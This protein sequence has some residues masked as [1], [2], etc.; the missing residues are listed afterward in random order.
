MSWLGGLAQGSG[1]VGPPRNP[2]RGC[3]NDGGGAWGGSGG[4]GQGLGRFHADPLYFF[5]PFLLQLFFIRSECCC[6]HKPIA[7]EDSCRD[8]DF[9]FLLPANDPHS[10]AQ[11]GCSH[12]I[13]VARSS[14]LALGASD[15]LVG[16]LDFLVGKP[17]RDKPCPLAFD[18]TSNHASLRLPPFL[19]CGF[20]LWISSFVLILNV[21]RLGISS[22][23]HYQ[24]QHL[25]PPRPSPL[26]L[27]L[28]TTSS[29]QHA[30]S[31]PPPPASVEQRASGTQPRKAILRDGRHYVTR[32][33]Q[34]PWPTTGLAMATSII[35]CTIITRSSSILQA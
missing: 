16:C 1:P 14:I 6:P 10:S 29:A 23:H 7:L 4:Q 33:N 28:T 25:L 32:T 20:H 21:Q 35:R 27:V 12:L 17:G 18:V 31:R 22:S 11:A 13:A 34:P 9:F 19:S 26:L 30:Q 5:P 8:L 3:E 2:F 15:L 24:F